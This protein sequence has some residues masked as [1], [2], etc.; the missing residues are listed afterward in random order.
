MSPPFAADWIDPLAKL[1]QELRDQ[2]IAFAAVLLAAG[3]R[4]EVQ[5]QHILDA[6]D[7]EVIRHDQFDTY[8]TVFEARALGR[9]P[10]E[11]S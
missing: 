11:G 3:G 4:V 5:Q 2:R 10:A 1:E 8:T 6:Y 9:T 7:A